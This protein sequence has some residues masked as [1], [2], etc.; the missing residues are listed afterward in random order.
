MQLVLV[1]RYDRSLCNINLDCALN[2]LV[3]KSAY[4][5]E[6]R[7]ILLT[8][9]AYVVEMLNEG[10]Y[11]LKYSLRLEP[12]GRDDAEGDY[13]G[14]N[15]PSPTFNV[16]AHPSKAAAKQFTEACVA[17]LQGKNIFKALGI[18]K[19][20]DDQKFIYD[21]PTGVEDN[22]LYYPVLNPVSNAQ[23]AIMGTGASALDENFYAATRFEAPAEGFNL[24]HLYF[25]GTV[26]N[27]E[28]VDIEASVILGNDVTAD[29]RT[30]GHGKL[31]VDY[32]EP[33]DNS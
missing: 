2:F 18:K 33:T 20:K 12:S 27:L 25:V 31:H 30:I 1:E 26:G 5:K 9:F 11:K 32:E 16:I 19:V 23:A 10:G 8:H 29:N 14:G 4:S 22:M 17:R 7:I 28:N 15:D 21:V 3:L 6:D 13:E 24:T